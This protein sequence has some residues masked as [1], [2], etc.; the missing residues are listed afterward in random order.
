MVRLNRLLVDTLFDYIRKAIVSSSFRPKLVP[1]VL[2]EEFGVFVTLTIKGVLRGCIGFI[3]PRPLWLGVIEAGRASA[4]ED[5]RFLPL[6]KSELSDLVIELSVLS[7][8]KKTSLLGVKVG[9]GLIISKGVKSA[10]FLPQVWD[11]LPVKKEFISHL[12]L[13]AGLVFG[14][15][16]VSYSKFT[17]K[18][19]KQL[20]VKR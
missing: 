17:V 5:P 7:R 1:P 9:D 20:F 16:G 2:K 19:Y 10:L 12:F 13:K 18:A 15:P 11:E 14:E 6:S 8:P 4:Y 3:E